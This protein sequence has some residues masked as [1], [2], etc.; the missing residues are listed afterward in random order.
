MRCGVG[1]VCITDDSAIFALFLPHASCCCMYTS[2]L[3]PCNIV[4][5]TSKYIQVLLFVYLE[6]TIII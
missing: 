3:L 4:L 1:G 5:I 6:L 2:V